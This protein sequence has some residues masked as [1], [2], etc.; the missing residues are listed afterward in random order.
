MTSAERA[1][2]NPQKSQDETVTRMTMSPGDGCHVLTD[3]N[4]MEIHCTLP[5]F[6]PTAP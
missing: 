1:E 2:L 6:T 3:S 4:A 5:S